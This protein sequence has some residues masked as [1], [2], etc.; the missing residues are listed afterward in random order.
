MNRVLRYISLSTSY[1]PQLIIIA[2]TLTCHL[3]HLVSWTPSSRH[4][5]IVT[6]SPNARK[7]DFNNYVW[8]RKYWIC[9][10][11]G[12]EHMERFLIFTHGQ[13]SQ[14]KCELQKAI[15]SDHIPAKCIIEIPMPSSKQSF[16]FICHLRASD[17]TRR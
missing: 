6:E 3:K 15:S 5:Y 2:Q 12:M 17:V 11:K 16:I 10:S 1:I 9:S 13:N 8:C 14:L 4:T 7:Y